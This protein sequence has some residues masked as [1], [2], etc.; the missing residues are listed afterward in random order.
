MP[1]LKHYLMPRSI[2]QRF[3][4]TIGAGA[5]VILI[6]LAVANYISGR[7][8]L[9]RQTSQEALRAVNDEINTMDDLV[10]RMAMYPEVIAA[11]ELAETNNEGV[12]VPWLSSLLKHSPMPAIYG[13]YIDRE[14]RDWRDPDSNPWVDR[15]S[16]PH[17]AHLKYDFHD[18]SQDWYR[19]AK[20]SK[21]LHV[22]QPYFDAGGSDIDMVSIT[23]PVYSAKGTF[24][25]VAGVDVALDEMRKI[26]RKIHIRNY[27]SDLAMGVEEGKVTSSP[28]GPSLGPKDLRETAY[29]ISQS[30]AIIVSPETSKDKPASKAGEQDP[31]KALEDLL[32]N[33][34]V[35]SVPGIQ[36]ILASDSGWQHLRDGSNKVIYWAKGRTT[37]WKLVLEVPYQLIVAPAAKLAQ[38]SAIIGGCG[39]ILLIGVV[40]FTA[41][42]VSQ[43]ITELQTVATSFERGSYEGDKGILE[44]IGKRP[45]ELGRFAKSFSTMVREIRLREERLSEWNANL[46]QTV[47][48]RTADLA[49]A[50]TK[51]EKINAAMQAELAEAA[52]YSRAVL[53]EKL[54]SPVSTDWVFISSS[55]LGG[56][57]FGYH[58]LDDDTLSLYLLDVCGH[59]VGAAL[60]SISVVNVLRIS[61]LADT[62]FRDPANVLGN[63]NAAFP[64]EQHNDMYFTAWYGVYTRSTGT[65]RFACG[66]HPPAVLIAADGSFQN[67]SA[68]GAVVG[69]FPKP[70]Y[71]T[72][73]VTVARGSRLYLFSDGTY[74]IDRPDSTMMTHEEF[75]LILRDS[76]ESGCTKL[77]AIVNE[78]RRQQ[79]KNDFADDFSLVEFR[80]P[81]EQFRSHGVLKLKADLG[82]VA[83]LHPFLS[84]YCEH[85]GTPMEQI[86]DFEVILEELVTNVIKYGG[87]DAGQ[88]CCLIE[89]LREG[90]QIT[91]RFSDWGNPFNPLDQGEVDTDKPIEEREIGGLGIHFIKKLTDTQSYE[92]RDRQNVLT[93]TKKFTIPPD[94]DV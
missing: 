89:L 59:G 49:S 10:E 73:S 7:E 70:T 26:V 72:A 74:E 19:G 47:K 54:T 46:E 27:E 92:Y 87:V 94:F 66:G 12:K 53:P 44:R 15:K 22:T 3:A 58:W 61:S 21:G 9:L 34:L 48:E 86:L 62:N 45:D 37:G 33:G 41:R 93:L 6:V 30:G 88:E 18:E 80:F 38:E 63:L 71:E 43:P 81:S 76:A 67:L 75:S 36:K 64:M 32:S 24:L 91:I 13:L 1:S 90:N 83:R 25:G 35:T 28:K 31:A 65:L 2:G 69:A 50:M 4:L 51:V 52:T 60:L 5:G 56:D 77:E 8:L 42:R 11:S 55:Q 23:K 84:S 40:F 17:A 85:E 82:E 16:W 20:E 68:K 78:V 57:S 29:L 39:L 14:C 79:G